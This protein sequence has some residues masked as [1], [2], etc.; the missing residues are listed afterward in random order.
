MPLLDQVHT[1]RLPVPHEI[2]RGRDTILQCPVYL[3]GA[4]VAP[5]SGTVMVYDEADAEIVS[6]A[7][8]TIT[9]SIA[10][11]TVT[12]ATTTALELSDGWRVEW[13]L[14]LTT[15]TIT[16]RNEAALVRT[17]LYPVVTD[18]DIVRRVKSLDPGGTAPITAQTTYQD[19]LDEA[20]TTIVLRLIGMGRRPWLV[21]SPSAL[22]GVHL[23]LTLAFIFEDLASRLQ[24][25]YEVRAQQHRAAFEAAWK[26]LTFRYD[27]DDD[28]SAEGQG[29]TSGPGTLW[30]GGAH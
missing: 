16:P 4:L 26:T 20:W 14:V 9:G 10:R 5:N 22:R 27:V 28:G 19:Y 29:R 24:S 21:L 23:E 12:G 3:S 8:V 1:A 7:A 30:F 13:T 2:I 17:A 6:A 11:Y 25:A 18:A 15:G